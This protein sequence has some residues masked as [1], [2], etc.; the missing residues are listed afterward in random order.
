[1]LDRRHFLKVAAGAVPAAATLRHAL[2]ADAPAD[3]TLRIATGLVE[4]GPD[5]IISTKL[6]NGQFPGPLLRMQEGKPA[7]IDV[8]NDTD[9]PE[10]LHLHGLFL[11][12]AL[13]G[14]MEEGTPYIPPHGHRRLSIVPAPSGERLPILPHPHDG[15]RRPDARPV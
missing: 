1:M 10:L 4:L 9:T 11:P 3:H 13:D 12:A 8:F 7:I 14:A 5:T 2:A 15:R 6:Y